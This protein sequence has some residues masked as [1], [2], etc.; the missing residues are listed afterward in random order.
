MGEAR[1]PASTVGQVAAA[2]PLEIGI[3]S[4]TT[5][6]PEE[7]EPMRVAGRRHQHSAS[8]PP[9]TSPFIGDPYHHLCFHGR[10]PLPF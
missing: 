5:P 6:V 1:S 10:R 9:T 7:L 3:I 8:T 4:G 2:I